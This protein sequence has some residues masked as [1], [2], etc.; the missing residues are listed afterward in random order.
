MKASPWARL[1]MAVACMLA[2]VLMASSLGCGSGTSVTGRTLA[3]PAGASLISVTIGDGPGDRIAAFTLTVNSITLTS[4]SNSVSVLSSPITVE[5]TQLAGTTQT[6]ATLTLPAGT[7]T[8]ATISLGAATV[9]Y[10]DP[11]TGQSLQKTLPAPPTVTLNLNPALVASGSPLVVSL[12]LNLASSIAIDAA[13]NISFNP[14]FLERHAPLFGA[15]ERPT[16]FN[17]GLEQLF[18]AVSG[19]SGTSFTIKVGQQTLTFATNSNT[20]FENING[21]GQLTAGMLVRVNGQVQSDGTLLATRVQA[22]NTFRDGFGVVGVI[23]T[24]TGSPATQ[25]QLFTR[26]M[27]TASATTTMP[28]GGA[29][30][31]ISGTTAFRFDSDG[32]DLSGLPFTPA[33]DA[34]SVKPGQLIE[35]DINGTFSFSDMPGGMPTLGT[36][37]AS[38]VE[39]EPQPLVGTVSGFSGGNT[40]TLTVA[41]DSVFATVAKTTTITVFKQAGT[42][43][44]DITTITNGSTVIVR[45]LLFL[46]GGQYKMVAGRIAAPPAVQ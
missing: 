45:G 27:A 37:T 3:P 29:V 2:A 17:G 43:L 10:V 30:I 36:V 39:L 20:V 23:S 26:A 13:G 31:N 14:R 34:T 16:P 18:G 22:V 33:F 28:L 7:Y 38:E 24:V 12:D 11:A 40:F 19:V 21:V 6:L 15:G 42:A 32:V 35:A 8:Q 5:I 41:A 46:D 4:G 1:G 9:T 44:R 25:L